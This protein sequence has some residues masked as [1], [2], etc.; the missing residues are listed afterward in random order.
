M[1]LPQAPPATTV[2][3]VP[4][5]ARTGIHVVLWLL[6]AA[7]T[8]WALL[9]VTGADRAGGAL[10][11]G[12]A[13]TPYVAAGS[14]AVLGAAL[15]LRDWRAAAVAGLAAAVLLACVLPRAFADT[16]NTGTGPRLRV[17]SANLLVGGADADA[18]V[19]LVRDHDVQ[20]LA[21]QEF[22][23]DAERRLDRAGLAMLLPHR[24]S[25][26][27]PGVWGSA[28]YS[29]YPLRDL[30]LRTLPSGATE[31]R[32]MVAVPG[33]PDVAVESAH[34]CAPISPSAAGCWRADMAHEP[35]ASRDGEVRILAGDF[36]STLD[37]SGLRR[38]IATGYRDAGGVSGKGLTPSWPFDGALIPPVTLD[39]VLADRRVG[40][41]RYAIFGVRG[42]DHRA[43][44][45]ELTLP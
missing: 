4:P 28:V 30:G 12:I 14:V 10:V 33:A 38:L 6:V 7:C 32:A 16:G 36:N 15:L 23:P 1:A 42:S 22:T 41:S 26:P 35:P 43:V 39:H 2:A 45:A 21:L 13:F 17:L 29:R 3:R 25:Y 24:V 34:P 18:V 40:V 9:R 20:V 5:V 27:Q 37:H 19:G 31:A 11:L 44:F 8:A